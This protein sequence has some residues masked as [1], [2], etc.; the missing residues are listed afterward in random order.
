MR[1]CRGAAAGL[2]PFDYQF[3][4]RPQT[5]LQ[6]S[7]LELCHSH[8]VEG[9]LILVRAEGTAEKLARSSSSTG[10][11]AAMDTHCG[12]MNHWMPHGPHAPYHKSPRGILGLAR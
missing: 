5:H 1:P 9:D 3:G 4:Q 8:E 12:M 10:S 2:A 7:S 6:E 11:M